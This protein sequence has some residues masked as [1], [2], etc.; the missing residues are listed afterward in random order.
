MLAQ[1][2]DPKELI[3][4]LVT[5]RLLGGRALLDAWPAFRES[6]DLAVLERALVGTY[7]AAFEA[8]KGDLDPLVADALA[9]ELARD[10]V[11]LAVRLRAARE[12][13]EELVA[14]PDWI[15]LQDLPGGRVRREDLWDFVRL[16]GRVEAVQVL[17]ARPGLARWALPL[18]RWAATGDIVGLADDL[19]RD[20]HARRAAGRYR[21]DPLG[22]GPIVAYVDAL[23]TEVRNVRAIA[24]GHAA[25]LDAEAIRS[26]VWEA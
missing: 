10:E 9:G 24:A 3:D 4:A 12:S 15:G 23:E 18:R 22:P 1:A 11:L 8:R 7:A 13:G 6:G 20:L 21:T 19:D 26:H 5:L 2:R 25:G 14:S 17:S 16:P